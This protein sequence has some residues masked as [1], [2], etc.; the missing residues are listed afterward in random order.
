MA[1]KTGQMVTP[2]PVMQALQGYQV[3]AIL[4]RKLEASSS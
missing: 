3:S 4:K 2:E 1:T